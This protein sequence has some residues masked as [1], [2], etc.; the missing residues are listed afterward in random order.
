M[1]I[2]NQG[3]LG[4]ISGKVGPVCGATWKG[5]AYLR[6]MPQSVANPQTSSQMS[7]RTR[8]SKISELASELLQFGVRQLWNRDAVKMSGFNEFCQANKTVFT[9]EGEWTPTE[10]IWSR[11]KMSATNFGVEWTDDDKI[12]L[13]FPRSS[14]D[15]YATPDDLAFAV[16]IEEDG[17]VA[18]YSV[19]TVKRSE[20]EVVLDNANV[21]IQTAQP[22]VWL[23]FVNPR[24]VV[25]NSVGQQM[26]E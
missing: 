24:Y 2:I 9:G 26:P 6:A 16:A 20:G 14:R 15:P 8:F 5:I 4:A 17:S 1:G 11:G 7:Q 10:F 13:T 19:G 21:T 22:Y 18:A 3:V 25:S 23:A 12:K